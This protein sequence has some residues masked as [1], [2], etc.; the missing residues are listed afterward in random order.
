MIL[1]PAGLLVFITGVIFSLGPV[2]PNCFCGF[3]NRWTIADPTVWH[4]INRYCGEFMVFWGVIMIYSHSASRE[5]TFMLLIIPA[6]L[7]VV[8]SQFFSALLFQRRWFTLNT[9]E[10][11][12]QL[13]N[14]VPSPVAESIILILPLT[15]V[16]LFGGKFLKV[17]EHV[18]V[19]FSVYGESLL[20]GS[21]NQLVNVYILG[22]ILSLLLAVWTACQYYPSSSVGWSFYAI[23]LGSVSLIVGY[24]LSSWLIGSSL[25]SSP[26]PLLVIPFLLVSGGG[27]RLLNEA[28]SGKYSSQFSS[29]K[30]GEVS[31]EE[32]KYEESEDD[33]SL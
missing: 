21:G 32:V 5:E 1:L 31:D 24:G 4:C 26:I 7:I 33:S 13:K 16:F 17:P 8:A 28:V 20:F 15:F 22:F 10:C 11:I 18:P 6:L 29:G 3:R 12:R 30:D 9:P 27:L 23:R 25:I 19:M 2:K 14:W